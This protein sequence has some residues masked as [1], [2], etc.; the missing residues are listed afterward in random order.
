MEERERSRSRSPRRVGR[1]EQVVGKWLRRSRDSLSRERILGGRRSRSG[2]SGQQNFPM[3]LTVEV[4]RDAVLD[5]HGFTLSSQHPLL[6]RDVTPG[7][8]ADGQL[9][10]G[11]QILKLNNKAI[12]DLSPE[13]VEQ[14]I[15]DC[16]DSVTMTILRN[17]A[18]PKSSFITAEKRAR[19]RRNPVKVRFAE[20]VVVNGHT[21]GN[22]LLFLPN[23]LKVYLE[24][25]QTKAFKFHKSTTVKN[26]VLTLK[27]KLSI[28][29]IEHF[30]LVLE[31]QYN[32]TKLLLLH[33]EE[34]IQ[35][36]VQKKDSHDYRCLFRVCF[37]PRDPMDLLQDDPVAF[38]YLFQQS[39]GDVLQERYAVEMKCN[40][41][42]RLAALHMHEKLASCGQTARASVKSVV[43]EF[44]LE[45]FISPTLLRN[46]REKDLRKAL[47][48]HMKKIQSLLEPHQKVISVSQARLAYLT[49]MAELI[50][51]SGRSYNATMLLQDRESLVTLLVGARYGI[52]QILNHQ[53]NMIST[54]IDFHYITR[55]EVL[56]ESDRV[57]M[58]K[59]YLQDIQPIAL[60]ME[61]VAAK[62]LACLL[63]GYCKLLVDPN[64]N[65]FRWGPR[66]KMRRIP[67][68]EGYVSRCGSDSEDSSEDDYAMEGLLDTQLSED[69]M[70]TYTNDGTEEGEEAEGKSEAEAEK[71][72][73][74]VTHPFL[75]DEGDEASKRE[76]VGDEDYAMIM[77][78]LL[79]TGWYTD[80]RVN[81]SFS[82][83]SSN[84]LNALE[85]SIK[86]AIGGLGHMDVSLE[87]KP[88][89][90][91]SSL[92]VHHPYLL[93]VPEHLDESGSSNKL[94]R[95]SE[96]TYDNHSGLCFS[97]LSQMSD[98]LP[99]PP[100]ASDDALS[101]D[102]ED[103]EGGDSGKDGRISAMSA[104]FEA[105][106]A[107][108]TPNSINAKLAG[109]N[110]QAIFTRIHNHPACRQEGKSF[111]QK[112]INEA[113]QQGP[114][115]KLIGQSVLMRAVPSNVPEKAKDSRDSCSESED[116]F[117][118][119]QDRFTPPITEQGLTE[120]SS[121]SENKHPSFSDIK[122]S[123]DNKK[124][125]ESRDSKEKDS[126]TP[127]TLKKKPSLANHFTS[128]IPETKNREL[129]VHQPSPIFLPKPTPVEPK[130]FSANHST[131]QKAQHCNGDIPGQ[132]PHLS[133]QLLEMEPDTM[134]FKPVTGPGPPLSSSLITAVRQATF[135]Q[136]TL[137]DPETV[138]NGLRPQNG[139]TDQVSDSLDKETTP[140][141]VDLERLDSQDS[142][143]NQKEPTNAKGTTE[144][145][146]IT[147][148][149]KSPLQQQSSDSLETRKSEN[150]V[151]QMNT[152]PPIPPKPSFI[153]L[154]P[155]SKAVNA[156]SQKPEEKTKVP[157]N[158]LSLHTWSQRNGTSTSPLSTLSKGVSLSHENLRTELKAESSTVKPTSASTTPT[159]SPSP[160]PSPS[161]QS[162]NIVPEDPAQTGTSFP[163]R[164]GSSGR[165]SATALR[166]KI[167]DMPWYLTRSQEIL[168]TVAL[169]NTISST[170]NI[171][172]IA[173][174]VNHDSK[175][176]SPKATSVPSLIDWK[177][178]DAEVV[179][180]KLK[181]GPEEVTPSPVKD[182][183][184]K[185]PTSSSHP[186]LRQKFSTEA[187][188]LHR[189]FGTC[190]SEQPQSHKGNPS[191]IQLDN[192]SSLSSTSPS[193]RDACGCH[194]V[195]ANCFSGD[196]EDSCSF[197]DDLTV[198]EFSRRNRISKPP[199]PTP[200]P[201][202]ATLSGPSP[203]V[204][205]LLRD[206]PRP[207][208]SSSELSPLLI[209][210]RPLESLPLDCGP[211]NN[212]LHFLQGHRYVTGQKGAGL[213]DS[214][215]CLQRDIDELLM[216]LKKGPSA[217]YPPTHKGECE[218]GNVNGNSLSETERCLVQAE[219]RRLASGCQ[220][221][222]RVGWA[223]DDALLSLGNSFGALVQLTSTCMRVPCSDCGSCHGDI[224]ADE[225][226]RKLEEIVD[227]YKEFVGAVEMAREGEG[228]RLLAKQCTV[229]ISTVFSLTQLFRTRTP[230]IDNGNVPLNF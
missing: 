45:S 219:A 100:A 197:D 106:L 135:P 160:L 82:S 16:Q 5:S 157:P 162:V 228:V 95:P 52:S 205:S 50:S 134:E 17:M 229:L 3:K 1:V 126:A 221:A 146:K 220:R 140:N 207:L 150:K 155:S 125:P 200:V 151:P 53:L 91:A 169:S 21:Q 22:S 74:I 69:T 9:F 11:D 31:Q 118:D 136:Q 166:G 117:F 137:V 61:S 170:G 172:T 30:A 202:P 210:P 35:K 215:A 67:A 83:L 177:E 49:Q 112:K 199:Q 217:V 14:M 161:V 212:P 96:L 143:P 80:P 115:S 128:A 55:I 153:G 75:E 173:T 56:S 194:T 94:R 99:S 90:G 25:G 122:V 145:G 119:A 89:S 141:H 39:V 147:A 86:A 24:N 10:P 51:Y 111:P 178:K 227:L 206:S 167:Q 180:V 164:T 107:S 98:S 203:N 113:K 57:S 37:I 58:L 42:L 213:K 190:K 62:D 60:L 29:C 2:D 92:D 156:Q 59:I 8:P 218:N 20:E 133:S 64:I 4:I 46:M 163:S 18:N 224:D 70:S 175:K 120:K 158:G 201:S 225:A 183:N 101:E 43:K 188:E 105:V 79:E 76:S 84:S 181:D 109:V 12:E 192:A 209:P 186:D 68:E 152:K 27:E 189:Y 85:E 87:E 204:L 13:N 116:E 171:A 208:P 33:E 154:Q 81:S 184:G 139:I 72:R 226:L 222:T 123:V 129:E 223:P 93:E 19:L 88:S 48:Y 71:V 65:V 63:A 26:I 168:G 127:E 148:D 230:D 6:V 66:P 108:C 195:Y 23:V 196:T 187:T 38:E 159:P 97:E 102:D 144:F 78:S 176:V 179:I 132:N 47:N 191:E 36:V 28:R 211:M 165:L 193:H 7:G 124:A 149:S 32:I 44:G 114:Y 104:E 185:P 142:K 77:D 138:Q 130:S 110:F 214:Y 15:R 41:A 216:V 131:G 174:D 121:D 73:V 182:T 34:L 198:Y 103:D 40:T 54:I